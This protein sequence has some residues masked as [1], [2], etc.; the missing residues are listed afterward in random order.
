MQSAIGAFFSA[1]TKKEIA[2]E[3][4]KRGINA[5]AIND[6]SDIFENR[7][8]KARDYWVELDELQYPRHIFLSNETENTVRRRAPLIGEHN[9][10][11]Y[12]KELHIPKNQQVML[13]EAGVI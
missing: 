1:L 8:L 13:T 9:D 12:S 6:P 5:S 2:D 10:E 4:M 3:G 7:Q 11:I